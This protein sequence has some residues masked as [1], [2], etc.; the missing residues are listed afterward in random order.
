MAS[1]A[2]Q[3]D[4]WFWL[5]LPDGFMVSNYSY[6]RRFRPGSADQEIPS[7][8]GA[9]DMRPVPAN[10]KPGVMRGSSWLQVAAAGARRA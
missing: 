9:F 8:H 3:S 6:V 5:I 10:L 2:M 4:H 7:L 1:P